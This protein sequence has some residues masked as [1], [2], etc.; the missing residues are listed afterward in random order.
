MKKN[1]NI[2]IINTGGTFN[3][4]YNPLKGSLDIDIN[5]MAIESIL[6]SSKMT[7][8][9]IDGII[10]KDSLD[11]NTKDRNNL[12]NHIN[13]SRYKKIIIIHGTDTMDKTALYLSNKIKNKQVVITGA[14]IPFS[15]NTVEATSNLMMAYGFLMANKKNNIYISMHGMV[16]KYNKIKKNRELG[17][18]ECL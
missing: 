17:I 8:N 6:K 4:V 12:L 15:I 9:D 3:K 1:E 7:N 11:L 13:E 16:K 10:Y 5:D 2:L 14:M 18:F